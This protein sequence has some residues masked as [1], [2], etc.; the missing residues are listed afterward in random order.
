M[1]HTFIVYFSFSAI[2]LSLNDSTVIVFT[3][4]DA[5]DAHRLSELT[6]AALAKNIKITSILTSQ[7]GKRKRRSIKSE[8]NKFVT[9]IHK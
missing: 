9:Q 5:K 8:N 2:E 7:C 4:A 3:D 6:K 1:F